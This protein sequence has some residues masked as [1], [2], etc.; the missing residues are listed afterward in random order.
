MTSAALSKNKNHSFYAPTAHSPWT[1]SHSQRSSHHALFCPAIWSRLPAVYKRHWS[2][3]STHKGKG[4]VKVSSLQKETKQRNTRSALPNA[5]SRDLH[6]LDLTFTLSLESEE[7]DNISICVMP[8]HP[9]GKA[10]SGGL[11]FLSVSD[12]SHFRQTSYNATKKL[13]G[14]RSQLRGF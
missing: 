14:Q 4:K 1:Q 2:P 7:E 12:Y 10:L 3:P 5:S 11:S 13:V 9:L 6:Q 8:G